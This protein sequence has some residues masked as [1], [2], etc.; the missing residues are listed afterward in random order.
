MMA[1]VES[2]R[3]WHCGCGYSNLAFDPCAGCHRPAPRYVR[4]NTRAR[5]M[6]ADRVGRVGGRLTAWLVPR[7]EERVGFWLCRTLLAREPGLRLRCLW[8]LNM[9]AAVRNSPHRPA[10]R[11][12]NTSS[13]CCTVFSAR[14]W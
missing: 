12:T 6:P 5:P 14:S 2:L 4:R 10:S 1:A 9:A 7:P 13:R 3:Y 8:P 11:R